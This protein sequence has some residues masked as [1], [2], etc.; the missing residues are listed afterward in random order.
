MFAVVR[1]IAVSLALL[2]TS[3]MLAS[4]Q[5][6]MAPA[7]RVPDDLLPGFESITEQQ[8]REWLS[9]LAGPV[10]SG[11]GT[12]QPGYTKAAHW[13][14]GKVAEF[15]LEPMGEGN[16]YFQF[17]PMK[18][19]SVDAGQ[20]EL[21]GP[22]GL[23]IA[24]AG[25][26]GL[27]RF[28]DQ[29]EVAGPL[30]F[31][32]LT[33]E[34]PQL[35]DTVNLRDRVVVYCCDEAAQRRAGFV[36][37]RQGA[38]ASFRISDGPIQSSTQ[39]LQSI[40]GRSTS[41]SGVISRSAARQL[42]DAAGVDHAWLSAAEGSASGAA[43][44]DAEVTIRLRIREESAAVPNVIALLPGS[45][46]ELRHEYLVVGAHLDHLGRRGDAVYP[47]ADD[48]GSGSTA[49]LGIARAL[50]LNPVRP[51]RSV[52]FIW[53]AAEEIGLVG[54]RHYVDNPTLPISDMICMLNIDMVGRDEEQEGDRPEDNRNTIHLIGSKRSDPQLHEIICAANRQVGFEFEYDEEDVF[55]RS[56]QANFFRK[57]VSAAFLFGGFHPDYHQPGDG[58]EKI[59][60]AKIAGA[61]RLFYL[62]AFLAAD[63]GRFQGPAVE[64]QG[65]GAAGGN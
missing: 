8:A 15:G 35:D 63:H 25:N 18:R 29:G 61:S 34:S 12:G 48:N 43:L 65:T 22:G 60:Y 41:L 33:G 28:A 38:A 21:T 14:A 32:R 9:I 37:A 50:A 11:R 36:I 7:E 46:P 20:S 3:L 23:Q 40:R 31:V 26:L 27:E 42:A 30:A 47:G 4:A 64:Q 6:Q 39:S 51:K 2:A 55:G 16:T 24:V 56:D 19:L 44:A 62:T 59:N 52:L 54:S 10:F 57:G 58:P 13:V 17:L 45:D 53:F 5:G 49:I 1:R